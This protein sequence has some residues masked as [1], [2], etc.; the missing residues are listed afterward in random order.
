MHRDRWHA[1]LDGLFNI[2]VYMDRFFCAGAR[3]SEARKEVLAFQDSS[4]ILP[5]F[6]SIAAAEAWVRRVERWNENLR[7][8]LHVDSVAAPGDSSKRWLLSP[9]AVVFQDP[10]TGEVECDLCKRCREAFA[11]ID[12]KRKQPA[13][14]MPDVARA[15]GMC[16]GP[17]PK[18]LADLTYCEAKVRNP[19]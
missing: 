19:S 3:L 2:E 5:K 11:G 10:A 18:E 8:E 13:P 17:D 15:N 6:S 12:N 1:A 7:T 4:D 9:T 16:R 14:R